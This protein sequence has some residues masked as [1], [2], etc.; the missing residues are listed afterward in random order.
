MDDDVAAL[1]IDNGS[2]MCKAGFAGD[3][4]PRA[5]F[6]S[7]VGRPRHQ[8]VMVGM[9]QKDSYVGDEAQSKRGILTLKYPIEHGIVTNW[10]D[11]E[12]IWHHTFYNEL[13]VAPE[14]HPVLL[15][16]APLNPKANREK[17]TQIMFETFNS[18]AMYVAIQAVLSLYASGRTTGIVLDSGDGVSHTVPIYEGYALP[19]AIMRLDLAGRDLTDYMMKILTE[20]GYSFTTTAER[21]IVRDIKEKLAYIA[22]D[23][24]QEMQTAA[25]SS[26]L[27]KSYE[28]PDGQVI[29]IG[30]ERFRCPEALFQPSFLGMESAGIHETTYNSIMKCDVDIRKD[31]YA[32][33]VLSGGTTMFPGIADRMQKEITALAPSTMKIKII[34]PPERKYSV[35]I[36]GSILASLSTFQQMWISKQEYD[37]SGPSIVHRKCPF[38]RQEIKND[39]FSLFSV[40]M[41]A[42]VL[43]NGSLLC[44]AGFAGGK[45][46]RS[47]FDNVVGRAMYQGFLSGTQRSAFVGRDAVSRRGILRLNYP[48]SH[49]IVLNWE[50]MELLW[51]HTFDN[52]LHVTPEE[53]PVLLTEAPLNPGAN[54]EMMAQI[55]FETFN[56]PS[57]YL[58]NQAALSLHASG[59]TT[60]LVVDSGAGVTNVV[61]IVDGR[62]V[63][64]GTIR[65][66]I[67]GND[68]TDFLMKILTE[69]GHSFSTT[70]ERMIMD[71]IKSSHLY[72][73]LNY[74]QEFASSTTL[75]RS[76]E[77]PNGELI[78]VDKERIRCPE[79]HFQ[80]SFIGS[81]QPG[82]HTASYNSIMKCDSGIRKELYANVVL[83]GGSTMFPGMADR[84][85]TELTALAP[86]ATTVNIIAH[87]ER[88]YFTWLGGAMLA[89]KS[90][91]QDVSISKQEYFE[92]GRSIVHSKF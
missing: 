13:R 58:A 42:V 60:G 2:G 43:D 85:K 11:M 63:T 70:S 67:G 56:V 4:A 26:S 3:D 8:G 92:T 72:V 5:V 66:D 40:K 88:E 84:M 20:R 22:L 18:P 35:W 74:E 65:V 25:S 78:T 46:P 87:P 59:R 17:M 82:I 57:L 38:S 27:E 6:P 80:P 64:A 21:E 9:G 36:G 76:Y 49:G 31:L 1:V 71:E 47:I 61:P 15:T 30:N 75:E 50:D 83:S 53:H 39:S 19:H 86:S 51:R 10:D 28:L 16:E 90:N 48:V 33:T 91:F 41:T 14:E 12:K 34:A 52:E 23:F 89:S 54:R 24:E 29:T 7:I 44:K 77:L 32:N 55:M 37:E 68:L 79:V 73:A 62:V 81:D 45:Q 69:R